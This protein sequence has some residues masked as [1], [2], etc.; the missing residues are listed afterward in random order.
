MSPED[1]NRFIIQSPA[2]QNC[3]A[4]FCANGDS[5]CPNYDLMTAKNLKTAWSFTHLCSL[6]FYGLFP[7]IVLQFFHQNARRFGIFDV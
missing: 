5:F 6:A 4:G 7:R 3:L 2:L 1:R